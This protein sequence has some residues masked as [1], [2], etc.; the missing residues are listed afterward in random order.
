VIEALYFKIS[1]YWS[2]VEKSVDTAEDTFAAPIFEGLKRT[3]HFR[4]L[5]WTA[6]TFVRDMQ[7]SK[8]VTVV[9]DILRNA[10]AE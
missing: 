2:Y 10:V 8:L 6:T 5:D 4:R 1:C 7:G 9:H 3:R